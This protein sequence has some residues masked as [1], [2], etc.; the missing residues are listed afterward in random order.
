MK[1]KRRAGFTMV[2]LLVV[3]LIIAMLMTMLMPRIFRQMGKSKQ[4]LAKIG[5][6]RLDQ[7]L[8]EFYI[9]CG[10]YP[11]AAEGLGALVTAPPGLNEKWGGV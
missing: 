2:E 6:S 7:A 4:G 10:R 11:T 1:R 5:I 9:D 8:Q 3:I